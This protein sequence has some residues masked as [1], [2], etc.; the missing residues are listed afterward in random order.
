MPVSYFVN[1]AFDTST[2]TVSTLQRKS[3]EEFI[4]G[5]VVKNGEMARRSLGEINLTD[6]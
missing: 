3:R 1:T 4:G 5:G 2:R 6:L